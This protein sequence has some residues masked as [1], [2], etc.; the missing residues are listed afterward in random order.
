MSLRPLACL[1]VVFPCFTTMA[2][3]PVYSELWG[4]NGE[5]WSPQSRLPDYSFA[6]YRC[7]EAEIPEPEVVAKVTDFGAVGNDDGDDTQAFLAAIDATERGA[8]LIPAGRYKISG[9]LEIHKPELVLRGEGPN[10]SVLEFTK[11][12]NE[13]RPNWGAT[14]GGRRTSNYSWS[15][16][17]V[18]IKGNFQSKKIADVTAPAERGAQT[19][20]VSTTEGMK[21]GQWI[22][23][24][25]EDDKQKTL[26]HH[27]Y[28]GDSG[29]IS[30]H[31]GAR[32]SLVTRLTDV[33]PE[34]IQFERPLRWDVRT[35]WSPVVRQFKPTVHDVG[36]ENL[37]FE[38]PA[39]PYRGHF[40]E[41]GFNAIAMSNVANCWAQNLRI[42]NSDSGLRVSG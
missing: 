40:T 7:G 35:A 6:G 2:Q 1:M 25:Q 39:D 14:T 21:V 42:N 29:D 23:I 37:G 5:K 30:K 19:L 10:Q 13:I 15:G 20:S 38:F 28:S 4:A 18:W 8:I 32:V 31:R 17:L 9:I 27:L 24:F 11:P 12:L 36:V 22:E 33:S 16:G 34:A 41:L 3:E 26:T